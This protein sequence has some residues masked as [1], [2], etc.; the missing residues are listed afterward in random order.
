VQVRGS[1]VDH[2]QH[3]SVRYANAAFCDSACFLLISLL[4][5][6]WACYVIPL[7]LLGVCQ[8]KFRKY[9]LLCS[10]SCISSVLFVASARRTYLR[11]SCSGRNW[12]LYHLT[13]FV[14]IFMFWS[15]CNHRG[16]SF[17]LL[18][19]T[20]WFAPSYSV[21]WSRALALPLPGRPGDHPL[22]ALVPLADLLNHGPQVRFIT[23]SLKN[24]T[25]CLGALSNFRSCVGQNRIC[26]STERQLFRIARQVCAGSWGGAR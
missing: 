1:S 25:L 12:L 11:T 26:H 16:L 21:F 6:A 19:L 2:T 20:L 24:T 22:P 8:T 18:W 5:C 15:G 13:P 4:C 10:L 9:A 14:N 23:L 3:E 7:F 17:I